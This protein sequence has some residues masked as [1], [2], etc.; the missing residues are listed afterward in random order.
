MFILQHVYPATQGML[1]PTQ[2]LHM[3]IPPVDGLHKPLLNCRDEVGGHSL[4]HHVV[5]ELKLDLLLLF[6]SLLI[7]GFDVPASNTMAVS[8]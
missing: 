6:P 2:P 5:L 3:S 7:D 1:I 8:K 4:A